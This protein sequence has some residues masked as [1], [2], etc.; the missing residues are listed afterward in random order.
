MPLCRRQPWLKALCFSGCPSV[1]PS[2]IVNIC[3]GNFLK[4]EEKMST[5][6]REWTTYNLEAVIVVRHNSGDHFHKHFFIH[7]VIFENIHVSYDC[8]T[9][10]KASHSLDPASPSCHLCSCRGGNGG[11]ENTKRSA[12]AIWYQQCWETGKSCMRL[13][14]ELDCFKCKYLYLDFVSE[15]KVHYH[16]SGVLLHSKHQWP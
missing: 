8:V 9:S 5:W 6:T 16:V 11:E 14:K 1:H 2:R 12:S 15:K 7:S 10:L 4:I 13:L 3:W